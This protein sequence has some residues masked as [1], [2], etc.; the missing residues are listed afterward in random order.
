[1]RS[2]AI[3]YFEGTMKLRWLTL[4]VL[5]GACAPRSS[6]QQGSNANQND[7]AQPVTDSLKPIAEVLAAHT[8]IW[9]RMPGVTGAGETQKDGKP[10]IVIIVD[11]MTESLSAQLPRNVEGYPVVF[12]ESGKIQAR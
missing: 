6:D 9:M 3:R 10:A 2:V 12:K 5:L 8:T 1:M 11:T 4:L 7:A